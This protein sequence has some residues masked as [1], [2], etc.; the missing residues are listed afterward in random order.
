MVCCVH[1]S[2]ISGTSGTRWGFWWLGV[3]LQPFFDWNQSLKES[4]QP[5]SHY[6]WRQWAS[7]ETPNVEDREGLYQSA[8]YLVHFELLRGHWSGFLWRHG[9]SR[10]DVSCS[11]PWMVGACPC[12]PAVHLS[13]AT[14][15]WENGS[16]SIMLSLRS[17]WTWM[18]SSAATWTWCWVFVVLNVNL[19]TCCRWLWGLASSWNNT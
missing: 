11:G 3:Q 1:V 8:G 9:N 7:I 13:F 14:H 4:K 18:T 17:A 16:A 10:A 19:P 12:S 15:L 2:L 6:V 5:H